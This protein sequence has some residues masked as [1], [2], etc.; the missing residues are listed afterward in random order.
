MGVKILDREEIKTKIEERLPGKYTDDG[1]E[2]VLDTIM[3]MEPSV[4]NYV[5]NY[6]NSGEAQDVEV[7]GYSLQELMAKRSMNPL[8]AYMTIDWII[9]EPEAAKKSLEKG[10]DELS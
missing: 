6:L 10:S 8:A 3:Q 2:I 1:I 5:E 9:K 4:R 7:E